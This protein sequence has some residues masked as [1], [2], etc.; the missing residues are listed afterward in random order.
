MRTRAQ[1]V[2]AD[3]VRHGN[4]RTS[5]ARNRGLIRFSSKFAGARSS[6]YVNVTIRSSATDSIRYDVSGNFAGSSFGWPV[7]KSH[8]PLQSL[9]V[10]KSFSRSTRP[11]VNIAHLYVQAAST[12]KKRSPRRT[13]RM[14][15][16]MISKC[17]SPP[18][19]TSSSLHRLTSVSIGRGEPPP[20]LKSLGRLMSPYATAPP[21]LKIPWTVPFVP[22]SRGMRGT[23]TTEV[24]QKVGSHAREHRGHVFRAADEVLHAEVL[25]RR[26]IVRA[27]VRA[28]GSRDGGHAD[29]FVEEPV[30]GGARR[31]R[32]DL[33]L[34]SVCIDGSLDRGFHDP[35]TQG[36]GGRLE[37]LLRGAQFDVPKAL[38][39]QVIPELR[40]LFLLLHV[41]DETEIDLR[42]RHR[43]IHGL[44]ALFDIP[45]HEAA[46]RAG[47]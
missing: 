21:E 33:R 18:S 36:D 14:A 19:G 39:N 31:P 10:I 43:R 29:H 6:Q 1:A 26:V 32:P 13:T 8:D 3:S 34:A 15:S 20:G 11:S 24:A 7:C 27:V 2:E 37:G 45:A 38:L 25:V 30:G 41:R 4:W 40:E 12:Q 17:F 16:P 9:H 5:V 28:A 22:L 42:L 46:D 44:R 23:E 47:G 35:G